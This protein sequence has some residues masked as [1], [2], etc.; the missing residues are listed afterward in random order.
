MKFMVGLPITVEGYDVIWVVVDWL[1]KSAH[2]IP[3]KVTILVEWLIEIYVVNIV[4]LH[5]V[6]LSI[7][8]DRDARFTSQFWR[9]VQRALGTQLKFSTAFDP[10]TDG[11]T[12]KTMQKLE[13]MLRSCVMD[14][15]GSWNKKLSLV[16]FSY[17]NSSQAYW[18]WLRTKLYM[19]ENVDL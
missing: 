8:S 9:W 3:I 1:I 16:E 19:G 6:P 18:A 5:G 14:F 11:R 13:D 17:N 2:F 10:Q 15:G 7:I 12:E 4:R